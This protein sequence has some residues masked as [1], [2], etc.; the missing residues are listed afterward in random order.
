[1]CNKPT[2]IIVFIRDTTCGIFKGG[3]AILVDDIMFR[4]LLCK[5]ED[6][7]SDCGATVL[8]TIGSGVGFC[9][10]SEGRG[11]TFCFLA[12]FALTARGSVGTLN[13]PT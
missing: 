3:K 9:V 4:V 5:I 6:T 11:A 10:G 1:M 7:S 2:N 8:A 13:P 12:F